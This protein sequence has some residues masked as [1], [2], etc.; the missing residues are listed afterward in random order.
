MLKK[1]ALLD[2]QGVG[3]DAT[4]LGAW[5]AFTRLE[6]LDPALTYPRQL[7]KLRLCQV[8]SLTSLLKRLV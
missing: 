1:R 2:P 8:L 5:S 6:L 3:E 7:T 4:I